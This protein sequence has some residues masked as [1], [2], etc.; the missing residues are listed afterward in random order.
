MAKSKLGV[1]VIAL[2]GVDVLDYVR[3][4]RPRLIV[5]MDH[6]PDQWQAVK[7]VSPDTFILGRYYL[8]DGEQLYLDEPEVRAT[9]FMNRMRP[10]AERMRGLYDA[11]MGYNENV[12]HSEVEANRL[13]RFYVQW[14]QLMRAAGLHA[15]AYS[16][17]TGNPAAGF[18][19]PDGE[20]DEPN[21]WPLLAPGA[22][23]CDYL[24]L[25]EYSAP[26]LQDFQGYLC[27]RY[28]RAYES[29]PANARR[30]ILITETGLDG[31]VVAGGSFAQKGWSFFTDELGY[32]GQ[33]QWYDAELQKDD[34]VLGAA[35]FALNPWGV[36]GSFSIAAAKRIRD[37]IGAE[38]SPPPLPPT[39]LEQ[40]V[41]QATRRVPWM[42]VNNT[43][44]LWRFAKSNG[45]QDQQTDELPLTFHGEN[46]I[47][48]VFNLGI[49]YVRVGDWTNIRVIPK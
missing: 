13:S 37:Y 41:M 24:A 30:P 15:A 18:P 4:A 3:H 34:H 29:L 49:V 38:G 20:G 1:Y 10:A 22:A 19:N 9:Q 5:S 31:G 8:D 47:V 11:W 25:H 28:R 2:S 14:G 46:Y 26:H 39:T 45:L 27:L 23:A 32:L 44:A 16:F 35:I 21:Y 12:I 43:A 33:L 36:N 17:A 7:Q 6:S 48:Q 40:A 42:P